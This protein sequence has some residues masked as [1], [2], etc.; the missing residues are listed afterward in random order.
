MEKIAPDTFFRGTRSASSSPTC[1][2][3]RETPVEP[4]SPPPPTACGGRLRR[5]SIGTRCSGI[6]ACAGMTDRVTNAFR[7]SEKVSGTFFL[8]RL[9]G[10]DGRVD[11]RIP[12]VHRREWYGFEG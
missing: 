9:R 4:S 2:T 12:D 10:N 5:G 6:P 11:T 7:L 8:R 3:D 1:S